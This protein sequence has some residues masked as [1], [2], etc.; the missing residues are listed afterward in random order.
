M[1][2]RWVIRLVLEDDVPGTGQRVFQVDWG[3]LLERGAGSG[4][5]KAGNTYK[6]WMI[7]GM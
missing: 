6:A 1:D 4:H 5:Q 3:A 2:G 7:P